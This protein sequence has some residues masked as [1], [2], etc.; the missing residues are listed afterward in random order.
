MLEDGCSQRIVFS[1]QTLYKLVAKKDKDKS[2]TLLL[3]EKKKGINNVMLSTN[4]LTQKREKG[5]EYHHRDL[6]LQSCHIFISFFL[7]IYI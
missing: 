6:P 2:D 3:W 1:L 7:I 4:Y 5:N